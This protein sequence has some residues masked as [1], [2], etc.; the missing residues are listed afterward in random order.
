MADGDG[1]TF[2]SRLT[3][4]GECAE[5][6]VRMTVE[7]EGEITAFK[8]PIGMS[9]YKL[10]YG[11]ACHLPVELEHK[12]FWAL[13]VLNFDKQAAGGRRKLQLNELEEFRIQ[14]YENAKIYKDKT[15][16]W[17]DQ[18]LA[19]RNFAEG[20]I[21]L[22]YN[23]RLKLFPGKL[24]SRWSGP[25]TITKVSPYSHVELIEENSQRTFTVNSHRLKHYLGES[26]EE[27]RVNYNLS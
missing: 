24:K 14:A 26:M 17:Q 7:G 27:H 8:T 19:Q 12:A 10:V 3:P 22:L 25:F 20:Q 5:K 4:I 13:K 15:K 16:K 1:G 9:P 2:E 11:K 21:V 6:G 18:R 23:S